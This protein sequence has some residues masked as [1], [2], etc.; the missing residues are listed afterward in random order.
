MVGLAFENAEQRCF[1]PEKHVAKG[2]GGDLWRSSGERRTQLRKDSALLALLGIGE[3][4][5]ML[6]GRNHLA[7]EMRERMPRRALLRDEQGEGNKQGVKAA[8]QHGRGVML[9]AKPFGTQGIAG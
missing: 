1:F 5:V 4:F 2:S 6:P 9:T 7:P 3:F 8:F